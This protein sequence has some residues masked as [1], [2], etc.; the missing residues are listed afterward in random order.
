[1]GAEENSNSS[2]ETEQTSQLA[3]EETV[4][5]KIDGHQHR[6][7]QKAYVQKKSDY[8]FAWWDKMDFENVPISWNWSAFLISVLWLGYRKMYGYILIFMSVYALANLAIFFSVISSPAVIIILN[9]AF[10][11]LFGAFGNSLYRI[12]VNK[13]VLMAQ[14][15]YMEWER[16]YRHLK[17]TGNTSMIGLFASLIGWVL[18]ATTMSYTSSDYPIEMIQGGSYESHPTVT[19]GDAFDYFFQSPKWKIVDSNSPYKVVQFKGVANKEE[20]STGKAH[21]D[22]E[23]QFIV[24]KGNFNLNRIKIDGEILSDDDA[25]ELLYGILSNYEDS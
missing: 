5:I 3:N 2:G 12:H 25:Y 11:I 21:A 1:M 24:E 22:V 20:D 6:E 15:K 18:F 13:K 7:L 4:Q 17:L 23:I 8:Y 19:V 14:N 9:F 10:P 16:Q